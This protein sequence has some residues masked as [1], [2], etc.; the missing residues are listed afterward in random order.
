MQLVLFPLNTP[1]QLGI[2]ILFY[3]LE[4]M[5]RRLRFYFSSYFAEKLKQDSCRHTYTGQILIFTCLG[6]KWSCMGTIRMRET[7]AIRSHLSR[8]KQEGWIQPCYTDVNLICF[9]DLKGF[10]SVT[11]CNNLY[12]QST[13]LLLWMW[14]LLQ[15]WT[16]IAFCSKLIFLCLC[17]QDLKAVHS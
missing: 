3:C 17:W 8:G 14:M 9:K 10:K 6:K 15:G 13:T 1:D 5:K 7:S 11:F 12:Q 4:V 2:V 16:S